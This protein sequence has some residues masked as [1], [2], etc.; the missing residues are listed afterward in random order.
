MN[1]IK[2]FA[3]TIIAILIM[4][5]LSAVSIGIIMWL[6]YMFGK[7]LALVAWFSVSALLVS[8]SAY[9]CVTYRK[10]GED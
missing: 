9:K 10:D 8:Y 6:S 4:A 2:A 1:Y 5:A 7:A 3:I